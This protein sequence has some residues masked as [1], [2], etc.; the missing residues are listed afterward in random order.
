MPPEAK[1]VQGHI[2]IHSRKER[3]FLCTECRQ[4]FAATKGTAFYRLRP[5]AETVSLVV[6]LRAHGCLLQALVVACG[7]DERT[8]AQWRARGGR[9]GQAVQEHRVVQPRDR[10]QVPADAI[11]VKRQG[12][13]VWMALVFLPFYK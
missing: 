10:G 5:S 11:R 4:T 1:P 13:I 2:G 12:G 8:V 9:Q 3:R 6:T 7:S